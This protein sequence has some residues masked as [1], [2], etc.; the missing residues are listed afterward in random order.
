MGHGNGTG[1]G[2]LDFTPL[3]DLTTKNTKK[4]H[5]ADYF[6][7]LRFVAFVVESIFAVVIVFQSTAMTSNADKNVRTLIFPR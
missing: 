7:L 3:L 6:F 1:H 5:K 4:K 2:I